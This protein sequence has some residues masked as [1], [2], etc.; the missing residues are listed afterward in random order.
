[1]YNAHHLFIIEVENRKE[2]YDYLK[3]NN[4]FS[5]IHYIPVNLLPYYKNIG[6]EEAD[7]INS[8]KYYNKCI[9]LPI[10]PTLL[11]EEVDYVIF[12]INKFKF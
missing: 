11:T 1:M 6:F 12:T 4:I 3:S 2:L 7:L 9:S 5:Q 8:E 10:F